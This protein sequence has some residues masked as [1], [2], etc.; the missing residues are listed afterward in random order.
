[1]NATSTHRAMLDALAER[2]RESDLFASVEVIDGL[3]KAHAKVVESPCWYQAGPLET[4]DETS[5]VWV[6]IYTPDR[7]LSGSIE[8]DVLHMGDKYEDLLEEELVDQGWNARL[9]VQHFR[10]DDKV[11]VFRSPVPVGPEQ[12]LDDPA[13]IERVKQ[14]VFAYEAAFRELGDMIPEED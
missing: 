7:W 1:M 5:H 4:V 14:G 6:G 8:A 11:F 9:N 3:L 13:L 2:C 10:D 12:A